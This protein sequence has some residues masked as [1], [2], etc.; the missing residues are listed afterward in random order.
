LPRIVYTVS[1][2]RDLAKIADDIEAA[3]QSRSAAE[4]LLAN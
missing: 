4:R 3:S 1:A 2:R